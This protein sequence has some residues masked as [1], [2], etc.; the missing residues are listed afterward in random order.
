MKKTLFRQLLIY[1]LLF[2]IFLSICSYLIIEFFFTDYYYAQQ[3]KSLIQNTNNLLIEYNQ[4]NLTTFQLLLDDYI[5]ESGMAF[6]F[7]DNKTGSLY[8]SV[9]QGPGRQN[10]TTYFTS[11][12]LDNIFISTI[13]SQGSK[14]DWISYLVKTEDGNMILGRISYTS[15]N[16]VVDIVQHFLLLFGISLAII[17]ALFAFFFSKS[18]SHP[19]KKLNNI[20]KKMSNLDFSMHYNG[21]RRDEIGELGKTLNELTSKLENTISQLQGELSKE[22][23]LENMRTLF[24]AQVSHEL[25]TP[26][27]VIKGYT[28]ALSDKIYTLDET[29]GIYDI[30]LS[31]TN[32][33]SYMVDD[34]LDL[35][36]MESGAY[37]LRKENFSLLALVEKIYDRNK[38]LQHDM[39]FILNLHIDYPK[40][41]LFFGDSLRLEQAIRN[42]LTNAIKHVKENGIIKI[43]LQYKDN[44]TLVIISNQGDRIFNQDLPY[45]FN[46]Y[47]QGKNHRSGKGLGLSI[48]KHIITL[49]DGTIIAKNADDGVV[50]EIVLPK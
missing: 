40:D 45:I 41:I 9:I 22:K 28:E 5:S 3:E 4:S 11:E 20:A 35:S 48:T 36:Q 43:F 8:G 10:L 32:K 13:G 21:K 31:E 12:N 6:L 33:I 50:F 27:S 47:Y 44:K 42:I 24:T 39:K 25:Q 30:L 19:L 7:L 17:F 2:G 46:S 14:S 16:E 15:I 18:M 49:H 29:P 38:M 37:I 23:T 26:L 1:L 34:L